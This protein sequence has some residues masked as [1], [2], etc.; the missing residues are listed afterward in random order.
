MDAMEEDVGDLMNTRARLIKE[1][2]RLKWYKQNMTKALTWLDRYWL[3]YDGCP[4][5]CPRFALCNISQGDMWHYWKRY[6]S[7]A[8]N[9]PKEVEK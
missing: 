5:D 6:R 4:D 8:T 7:R 3:T 1:I 2:S 9:Y